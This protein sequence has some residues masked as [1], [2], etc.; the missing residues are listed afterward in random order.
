MIRY[1][2][3]LWPTMMHIIY[4]PLNK[5]HALLSDI[6]FVWHGTCDQVL[7]NVPPI[8]HNEY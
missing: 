5:S 7:W 6:I 8:E 1:K 2:A 4:A 3:A